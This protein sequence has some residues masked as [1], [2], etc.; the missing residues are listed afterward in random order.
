MLVEASDDSS[1][2]AA[3]LMPKV[4]GSFQYVSGSFDYT[5]SMGNSYLFLVPKYPNS[6]MYRVPT[7]DFNASSATTLNIG[8]YSVSRVLV[9]GNFAYLLPYD[10][11]SGSDFKDC[12]QA[13]VI[14]RVDLDVWDQSAIVP[15]NNLCMD[16]QIKL[17]SAVAGFSDGMY[18]Y[19]LM[20]TND[21][22]VVRFALSDFDANKGTLNP[23][24]LQIG[25]ISSELQGS[26]FNSMFTDGSYLYLSATN[27]V[28]YLGRFSLSD[29]SRNSVQVSRLDPSLYFMA[30]AM[31]F[32]DAGYL[33]QNGNTP[34]YQGR[35]AR[36]S[37]DAS[38]WPSKCPN[39]YCKISAVQQA[40]DM[41]ANLTGTSLGMFGDSQYAYVLFT[42]NFGYGNKLLRFSW[43]DFM[44]QVL[45]LKS[46]ILSSS[47]GMGVFTNVAFRHGMVDTRGQYIYLS[48]SAQ[49]ARFDV[50]DNSIPWSQPSASGT[51]PKQGSVYYSLVSEQS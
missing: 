4:S 26:Q 7:G 51:W 48:G 24:V 40:V 3:F 36:F 11:T 5:D 46:L 45:D 28:G 32:G 25:S 34:Y 50:S 33:I 20:V 18:G 13:S 9:Q 41:S 15:S 30:R 47:F 27:S 37:G 42:D 22:L 39:T 17:N 38:F 49:V 1:S 23:S 35:V 12:Q 8:S 31:W 6:N 21:P 10:Y 2:L 43:T 19:L 14:V 44:Y 29:F 16:P